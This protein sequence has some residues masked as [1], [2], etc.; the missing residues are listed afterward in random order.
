MLSIT[1]ALLGIASLT[2]YALTWGRFLRLP[3]ALTLVSACSAVI[4]I[5][6]LGALAGVLRPTQFLVF[7]C[8]L[9]ALVVWAARTPAA[10]I[11]R[12]L[13]AP[14]PVV[15]A[16]GCIVLF[17]ITRGLLLIASDEF[18]NWGAMSKILLLTD[19]LPRKPGS[20]IFME[21]LPGDAFFQ[22]FVAKLM[23]A[24]EDNM[25]FGHAVFQLA[26]VMTLFAAVTW[27][28]VVLGLALLAIGCV[29]PYI[30]GFGWTS[31]MM[32]NNIGLLFACTLI[33]YFLGGCGIRAMLCALPVVA[34][35]TL[36][37][38]VGFLFSMMFAVMVLADKTVSAL[39]TGTSV[40]QMRPLAAV[41]YSLLVLVPLGLK[42]TWGA[43]MNSIGAV[44]TFKF[45][46]PQLQRVVD[47]PDFPET[48][49]TIVTK[50]GEA[51]Q[52]GV[53]LG[54]SRG[55][56][57]GLPGW[58][59]ILGV[60]A[61][62][63]IVVQRT[64]E[65]RARILVCHTL[66]SGFLALLLLILLCFYIIAFSPYEALTVGGFGRY[67]GTFIVAW[68]FMTFAMILFDADELK[69]RIPPMKH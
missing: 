12:E 15:F 4:V 29:S 3:F 1:I 44:P 21:F 42:A 38:E 36:L 46:W 62:V 5:L 33:I 25:L 26:M 9:V 35:L 57:L 18:T 59:A 50:F 49:V 20:L 28:S 53:S 22:Y 32:D 23:G 6:Y 47:R 13:L 48:F 7:G 58:C 2:G 24:E 27:R 64:N 60:L 30:F 31:L 63:S 67:I 17:V 41:A 69:T 10:E 45:S 56:L 51:L 16:L 14:A 52:G 66:L 39:W 40:R 37:K 54:F 65:N 55:G 68:I 8:G 11:R 34:G 61:L 19:Q 43:H